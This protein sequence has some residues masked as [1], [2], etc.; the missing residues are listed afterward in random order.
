MPRR[1]L[2]VVA[3]VVGVLACRD[4]PTAVPSAIADPPT[5]LTVAADALATIQYVI[6][7][8]FVHALVAQVQEPGSR[9]VGGA[10]RG[11]AR[12]CGG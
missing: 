6:D 4:S 3:L 10:A 1:R 11:R 5:A 7:D 12:R 8:P 2:A 9:Q